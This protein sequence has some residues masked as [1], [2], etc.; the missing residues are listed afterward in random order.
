[1]SMKKIIDWRIDAA[2]KTI[3][4]V[5]DG[6]F[7]KRRD[8][9]SDPDAWVYACDVKISDGITLYGVPISSNNRDVFYSQLKKPV[10][11]SKNNGKWSV[12]GLSKVDFGFTHVTYVIF[13]EDIAEVISKGW[14]G[15]MTR[16]LTYGELGSVF[17]A[18][19][20]WIPYGAMGRFTRAGVFIELVGG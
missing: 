19:Y 13:T 16:P 14:T 6:S 17:F 4:G 5:I 8:L 11:L 1:M 15:Y 7:T 10:T 12:T 18:G 9:S 3:N 20:G 2:E